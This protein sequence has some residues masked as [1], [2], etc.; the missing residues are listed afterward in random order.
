MLLQTRV[1]ISPLRALQALLCT[2]N[3]TRW[4]AP[5]MLKSSVWRARNETTWGPPYPVIQLMG[6][7]YLKTGR[8]CWCWKLL[9]KCPLLQQTWT[10]SVVCLMQRHTSPNSSQTMCSCTRSKTERSTRSPA[11]SPRD[12]AYR[13]TCQ[14]HV[15]ESRGQLYARCSHVREMQ[16]HRRPAVVSACLGCL[17]LGQGCHGLV[18]EL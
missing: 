4:A 9:E 2:C 8:T 3:L 11:T 6:V 15:L 10:S 17:A 12:V 7:S 13:K 1:H 18:K 5:A 16:L 14:Q